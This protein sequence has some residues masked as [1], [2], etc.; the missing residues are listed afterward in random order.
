MIPNVLDAMIPA[1]G[2]YYFSDYEYLAKCPVCTKNYISLGIV[3]SLD[4]LTL[5]C[6]EC[7]YNSLV[8]YLS[9]KYDPIIQHSSPSQF[10]YWY[11]DSV[12]NLSIY[13]RSIL[14]DDAMA[15]AALVSY[16]FGT[17]FDF[18][19]ISYLDLSTLDYNSLKQHNEIYLWPTRNT[20]SLDNARELHTDLPDIVILMD[21]RLLPL[22]SN[23]AYFNWYD[24]LRL[25]NFHVLLNSLSR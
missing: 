23:P 20:I 9:Q 13:N 24:C 21:V 6:N 14:V 8:K 3:K 2:A 1:L 4:W 22:N 12:D 7:D 10:R 5:C 11:A 15:A 18:N 17:N 16:G 25:I 19:V